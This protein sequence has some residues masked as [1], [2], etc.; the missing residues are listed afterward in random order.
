VKRGGKHGAHRKGKMGNAL[1]APEH[2]PS[3]A[4]ADYVRTLVLSIA[5]TK[6]TGAPLPLSTAGCM[7]LGALAHAA[8]DARAA[9]WLRRFA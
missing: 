7:L 5:T 3:A 9:R 6:L 4:V 8:L 2:A 1:G